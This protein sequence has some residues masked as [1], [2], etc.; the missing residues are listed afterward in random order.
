MD[1]QQLQLLQQLQA[2]NQR[3]QQQVAQLVALQA[4]GQAPVAPPPPPRR[5]IPV[6]VPDKFAGQREMFPTF[7]GQCQLFMALRPEDFPD[8]RARVGF[9]ISLLS[10]SA[11]QWATPLLLQDSPLLTDLQGFWQ[12]MRLLYE[13][14]FRPQ[15]AAWR[16]KNLRQGRRP[17]QD[18]VAEFRLLSQDA[19]WNEAAL[20]DAFQDGLSDE[21]QDE[22]VRVE[23]PL[24]L[25]ALV[26]QCLR[27]DHRLTAQE[28][29]RRRLGGL[30]LYCGE[31]GHFAASCPRKRGGAPSPGPDSRPAPSGN[32][33]RP[34]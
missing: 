10:G 11:A 9:V 20:M 26:E 12:H 32:G 8:D 13:D 33:A 19:R 7:M 1:Q 25:D 31:P 30:C 18:Y 14:P 3:L 21:L 4:A 23:A 34:T 22:L 17:L 15:T 2:D 16:I 29:S 24:T 27:M 6:S 5:K 28:R